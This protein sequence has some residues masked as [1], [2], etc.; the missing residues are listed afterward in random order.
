MEVL[1]KEKLIVRDLYKNFDG[2]DVLK[3]ISFTVHE[4]EFLSVLGPAAA[5]R[6]RFC[7]S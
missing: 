5:A 6:Q 3:T 4:G 7:E 2:K 1:E